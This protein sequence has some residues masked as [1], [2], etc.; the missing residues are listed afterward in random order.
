[1]AIEGQIEGEVAKI[2]DTV[3]KEEKMIVEGRRKVKERLKWK[4]EEKSGD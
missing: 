1:V 2:E 4:F 3:K